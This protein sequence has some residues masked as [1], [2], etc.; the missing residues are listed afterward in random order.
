[1]RYRYQHDRIEKKV[2][3]RAP[4]DRVWRAISDARQIRQ[5]VGRRI[6]RPL[7]RGRAHHWK[8]VSRLR[9][10]PR[11]SRP[12]PYEGFKLEFAI[13]RIEPRNLF[14]SVVSLRRRARHRVLEEAATLVTF[15]LAEAAGGTM[16]T[17]TERAR[18]M[19]LERRA[20]AFAAKQ[21]GLGRA[22]QVIEEH[23]AS[24]PERR[25]HRCAIPPPP[26][27][28]RRRRFRRTGRRDSPRMVARLCGGGPMSIVRLADGARVSRQA[29]TKHLH[30]LEEADSRAVRAPAASESGNAHEAP[31]RS[32]SV[33]NPDSHD[34]DEALDR[35][36]EFVEEDER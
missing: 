22:D 29:I 14:P 7:R 32:A 4:R 18:S 30:A 6:R 33:L 35:L 11:S 3:L 13:D 27:S 20:K 2:L 21:A 16:L 28:P 5:L 26:S 19:P 34:W 10:T 1:M 12:E 17:V 15:E 31:V 23:L 25:C 9:S 8:A 36:R 24:R